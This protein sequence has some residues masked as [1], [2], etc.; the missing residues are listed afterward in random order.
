M[1]RIDFL[2]K[3]IRYGLMI[4]LGLTVLLLGKKAAFGRDCTGCPEIAGCNKY[5][6][7]GI[8]PPSR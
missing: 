7:S 1:T 2:N 8:K 3:V 6:C 5:N 4:F